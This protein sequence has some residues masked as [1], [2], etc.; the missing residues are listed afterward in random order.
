MIKTEI[1]Q[2]AKPILFS[3][4]MVRAILVGNKTQTRRVIK[5]KYS[6]T[7]FEMRTDKY[8][9]RLIEIE[10]KTPPVDNG[11]GTMRHKVRMAIDVAQRFKRGDLLYVRETWVEAEDYYF[12]KADSTQ[13]MLEMLNEDEH[14]WRPSIHM[15][16][17]AARLF[18]RVTDVR[19]E[20]LQDITVDDALSEGITFVSSPQHAVDQYVELWNNLNAKRG[21]SWDTNPWVWV[22]TFERVVSTE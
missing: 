13:K 18:L 5:P 6:N 15:P 16:K 17:Q 14:K 12:Y 2:T 7:V 3:G 22:Y 11:N 21:Y 8:G 4:E 1:L 10:E 19:V 20:R 9:T